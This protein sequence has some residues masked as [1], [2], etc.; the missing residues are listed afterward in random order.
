[1]IFENKPLSEITETDI[2]KLKDNKIEECVF[3]DYKEKINF[4][5]EQDWFEFLKDV[6]ALANSKGG[7]IIYG[8]AEDKDNTIKDF[9][10]VDNADTNLIEKMEQKLSSLVEP[11][12]KFEIDT[13]VVNSKK[14]LLIKVLNSISKPHSITRND[15]RRYPVRHNKTTSYMDYE[16]IRN[17]FLEFNFIER[18]I[19]SWINERLD[20]IRDNN[21]FLTVLTTEPKFI[22]HLY[23]LSALEYSQKLDLR[24]LNGNQDF[25]CLNLNGCIYYKYNLGGFATYVEREGLDAQIYMQFFENGVVEFVDQSQS[26][27][28][29]NKKIIY[30]GELER[31][32]NLQLNRIIKILDIF[33]IGSPYFVSVNLL[34]FKGYKTSTHN[35]EICNVIDL[36]LSYQ[37]YDA[38]IDPN[39]FTKEILNRLANACGQSEDK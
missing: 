14:I 22:I 6:V 20:N 21:N 38:V 5:L 28:D 17:N 18:K 25:R 34:D 26:V 15:F 9:I 8:A 35:S 11:K 19:N 16:E 7:Y 10:N 3:L 29:F 1:M 31:H 32:L 27:F 23:P 37:L 12:L 30:P 39:T 24:K 33:K 36:K 2:I 13:K 4:S